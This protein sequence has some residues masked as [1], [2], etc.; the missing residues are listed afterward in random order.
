[1]H[2]RFSPSPNTAKRTHALT[3]STKKIAQQTYRD[4][5]SDIIP[6]SM[7]LK[8]ESINMLNCSRR[9]EKSFGEDLDIILEGS[10]GL[11]LQQQ[12]NCELILACLQQQE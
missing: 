4:P 11:Q 12:F 8:K 6:T 3:D 7:S 2:G 1:M 5:I 9:Q 10:S